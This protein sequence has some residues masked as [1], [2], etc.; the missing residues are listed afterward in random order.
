MNHLGKK[1]PTF[2]KVAVL[3][4]DTICLAVCLSVLQPV[5]TTIKTNFERNDNIDGYVRVV[6]EKQRMN[7][8][9]IFQMN[10]HMAT[11]LLNLEKINIL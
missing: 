9:S 3:S 5:I 4:T 7:N 2:M 6:R 11:R 10:I 8:V 1:T